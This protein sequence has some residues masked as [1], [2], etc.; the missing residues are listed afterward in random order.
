MPQAKPQAAKRGPRASVSAEAFGV[1][2]QKSAFQPKV[3]AKSDEAKGQ[4]YEKLNMAF[5]FSALDDKEKEIV[6]D[7]MEEIKVD[8]NDVVI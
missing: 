5:M 7:A 4:I 2:N 3:I 8:V 1:W 6:V